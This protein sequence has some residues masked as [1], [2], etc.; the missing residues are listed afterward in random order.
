MRLLFL[1][2][3]LCFGG[4]ISAASVGDDKA[5]ANRVIVTPAATIKIIVGGSVKKPGTYELR[6]PVNL[7]QAIEAAGG[8]SAFASGGIR[9]TSPAASGKPA[10]TL[11]V[12]V[13]FKELKTAGGPDLADG[14]SVMLA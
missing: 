11:S 5:K 10:R 8:P 4:S 9:I 2:V 7:A 3:L 14:D 12:R 1:I 13:S 6:L